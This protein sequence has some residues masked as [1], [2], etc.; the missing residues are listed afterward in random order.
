MT[1]PSTPER[2]YGQTPSPKIATGT[3]HLMYSLLLTACVSTWTV[4]SNLASS[5]AYSI[6]SKTLNGC[7]DACVENPN[8]VAVNHND[9]DG[10]CWVHEN[11]S[12]LT[13]K[14]IW[15]DGNQHILKSRCDTPSS[16]EF[17]LGRNSQGQ[18]KHERW[19]KRHS[20]SRP[21]F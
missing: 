16:S 20:F 11:A 14:W 3:Q 10:T 12:D 8:C 13:T 7:R 17:I 2:L 18:S 21:E 1:N 6:G 9:K 19:C 15:G 4:N 5:H